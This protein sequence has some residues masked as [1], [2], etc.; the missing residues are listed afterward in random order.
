MPNIPAI[1][2]IKGD[3]G[4]TKGTFDTTT[5]QLTVLYNA[6]EIPKQVLGNQSIWKTIRVIYQDGS[7]DVLTI[8]GTKTRE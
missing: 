3:C 1:A 5:K 8:T 6:G 4:C 7:E 2:K